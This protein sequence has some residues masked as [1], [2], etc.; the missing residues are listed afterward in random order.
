MQIERATVIPILS[1]LRHDGFRFFKR[2]G[3]TNAPVGRRARG[4]RHAEI[5]TKTLK[6][7]LPI[8]ANVVN[9]RSSS[10][11]ESGKAWH[12][13][14]EFGADG[15]WSADPAR[16]LKKK[17]QPG[18][19]IVLRNTRPIVDPEL[20]GMESAATP[21]IDRPM[22]VRSSDWERSLDECKA[23]L[24]VDDEEAVLQTSGLPAADEIDSIGAVCTAAIAFECERTCALVRERCTSDSAI[25]TEEAS[26]PPIGDR[27]SATPFDS[28][29]R[30]A[31]KTDDTA[32]T[33][34][35]AHEFVSLFRLVRARRARERQRFS[36][37]LES[38]FLT[39]RDACHRVTMQACEAFDAMAGEH[40]VACH[41]V[42]ATYDDMVGNLSKRNANASVGNERATTTAPPRRDDPSSRKDRTA[43]RMAARWKLTT[44][45]R[46]VAPW[47]SDE[48][49]GAT[50]DVFQGY[51]ARSRQA[52]LRRIADAACENL[53]RV[54]ADA[55][56]IVRRTVLRAREKHDAMATE[57]SRRDNK[58]TCDMRRLA[59]RCATIDNADAFH[60]TIKA[61]CSDESN[62]RTDEAE[63]KP[64]AR[65]GSS[66][67]EA[68]RK[69][70]K[71]WSRATAGWR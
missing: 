33:A 58:W 21:A 61:F 38:L 13:C 66:V 39:L 1:V 29:R 64:F 59:E 25:A 28:H 32:A 12:L 50:T 6:F 63:A 15:G 30:P 65:R 52:R 57:F 20:W 23:Q 71:A 60:E 8:E 35:P 53:K 49:L 16:R 69:F 14:L 17:M 9:A 46:N 48:A 34:A 4:K 2:R 5:R 40:A 10:P 24:A 42:H 22:V 27:I 36:T 41:A 68:N 37:D 56:R 19:P 70:R 67:S 51:I 62:C 54:G 18:A 26:L 31:N 47:V 55:I 43:R 3:L 7:T 11:L 45:S 44:A